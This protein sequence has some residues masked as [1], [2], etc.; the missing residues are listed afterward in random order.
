MAIQVICPSCGK[1]YRLRDEVRGKKFRCKECDEVLVA[2]PSGS[3]DGR[4]ETVSSDAQ[5]QRSG[6]TRRRRKAPADPWAAGDDLFGSSLDR[7]EGNFGEDYPDDDNPYR[8]PGK[9]R[10]AKK[11]AEPVEM[12][13]PHLLFGFSGRI[14]RN[15]YWNV[16]IAS[17][18]L[19]WLILFALEKVLGPGHEIA[20][21]LIALAMLPVIM[22]IG[23]AIQVK[24]WH[25]RGKTGWMVLIN[26]IPFIGAI[27]TL[28]E[29]GIMDGEPGENEYGPE[30]V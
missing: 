21:G 24:R 22:W 23:T 1:K 25:D 10:I 14:T 26:L 20:I 16:T 19:T 27:W 11:R 6:G 18:V 7:F 12:T 30:P 29:C 4:R 5:P 3:G 13:L 17:N 15:S 28:I 8:T 9:A 2:K